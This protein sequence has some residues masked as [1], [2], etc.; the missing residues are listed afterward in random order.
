[1]EDFMSLLKDRAR[2]LRIGVVTFFFRNKMLYSRLNENKKASDKNWEETPL[3]K[4]SKDRFTGMR[5]FYSHVKDIM[6]YIPVWQRAAALFARPGQNYD[7]FFHWRNK[8]NVNDKGEVDNFKHFIFSTG[9]LFAPYDMELER[10]G[11]TCILTWRDHRDE[12]LARPDDRLFIGLI[13]NKTPSGIEVRRDIIAY[14]CDGRVV[15]DIDPSHDTH[16]HIYPFFGNIGDQA[17]SEND[18]F[19]SKPGR[20][21]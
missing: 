15:F 19:N 12:P 6:K 2:R 10:Q 13:Y 18:Y 11:N 17:F 1:M 8:G 5:Y 16:V 7:N 21:R 4:K 9:E 3:R 20:T 14:R